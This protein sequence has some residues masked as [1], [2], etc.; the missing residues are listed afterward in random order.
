MHLG[1]VDIS[2]HHGPEVQSAQCTVTMG[3]RWEKGEVSVCKS[4]V[5]GGNVLS[6]RPLSAL[7]IANYC[8]CNCWR[9]GSRHR[10]RRGSHLLKPLISLV[11]S[12]PRGSLQVREEGLGGRRQ[13]VWPCFSKG[14]DSSE[15]NAI[16]K[17]QLPHYSS[18]QQVWVLS[19]E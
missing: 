2:D 6:P 13:Q 4:F 19:P 16:G 14:V 10:W 3:G 8:L 15:V 9:R 7:L 12:E 5:F 17:H 18:N 1:D 11:I